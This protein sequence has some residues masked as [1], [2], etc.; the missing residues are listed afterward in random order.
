MAKRNL[1]SIRPLSQK[2]AWRVLDETLASIKTHKDGLC[3]KC[4]EHPGVAE[5]GGLCLECWG[6]YDEWYHDYLKQRM[7]M[8]IEK[9]N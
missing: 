8:E 6:D 4:G 9:A 1:L 5:Y 2:E 3:L 7:E